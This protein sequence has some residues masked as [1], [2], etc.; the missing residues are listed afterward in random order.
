MTK[1]G[2]TMINKK[3]SLKVMS[4]MQDFSRK[5]LLSSEERAEIANA[6]KSY[7]RYGDDDE[8]YEF[9]EKCSTEFKNESVKHTFCKLKEEF[10]DNSQQN[11]VSQA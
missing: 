3:L 10:Y 11:S 2:L 8:F 5:G 6:C 4:A 1:G 9:L 7:A